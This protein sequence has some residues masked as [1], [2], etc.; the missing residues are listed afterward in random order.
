MNEPYFDPKDG[1]LKVDGKSI[2]EVKSTDLIKDD[3]G[4]IVEVLLPIPSSPC[5]PEIVVKEY[6]KR[7]V[8][9]LLD[10][11][12]DGSICHSP[13]CNNKHIEY[14]LTYTIT[15]IKKIVR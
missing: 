14:E 1:L 13:Y 10:L 8:I 4:N 2:T 5:D 7:P 15:K 12:K 9:K 3:D 11:H 6:A